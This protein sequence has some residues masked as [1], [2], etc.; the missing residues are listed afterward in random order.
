M[1]LLHRYEELGESFNPS[2]VKVYDCIRVNTQK[3]SS[4][5]LQK[6][7]S[8]KGVLLEKISGLEN[9]YK[10]ESPFSL[11]SCEEYLLGYFYLQEAASQLPVHSLLNKEN[12]GASSLFLDM[13]AAPGSKTTQLAQQTNQEGIIFALDNHIQRLKILH[14]NLERMGV[15]NVISI[16]KEAQFSDDLKK[17]FD[18]ILLDAPCSGNFCIEPTYFTHRSLIDIKQRALL[19]RDLLKTAH[20]VLKSGGVLV[21]STCSLEPEEN[22]FVIDWFLKK[23]PDMMIVDSGLSIGDEAYTKVFSSNLDPGISKARRIWPHKTNMQ[24]FFVAKLQKQ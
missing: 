12:Y 1:N 21:Y 14:H 8:E 5:Q 6:R 20:K 2:E 13:C 22:E 15:S 18:F 16:R 17:N 24:G 23:Y 10:V 7:L 9:A 3:I 4:K 19:Q 11:S